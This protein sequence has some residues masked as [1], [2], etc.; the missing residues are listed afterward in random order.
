MNTD[1][2]WLR[3]LVRGIPREV[4]VEAAYYSVRELKQ[5]SVPTESRKEHLVDAP[6]SEPSPAAIELAGRVIL[7]IRERE[8]VPIDNLSDDT[9]MW[10]VDQLM[11]VVRQVS[12]EVLRRDPL[13][14]RALL[15]RLRAS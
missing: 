3:S 5:A 15:E 2:R 4:V 11:T 13:K 6:E 8:Q 1:T 14:G 12:D 7:A 10:Y 9:F